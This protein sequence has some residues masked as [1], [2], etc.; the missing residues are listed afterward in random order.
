MF[1]LP[2]SK[3]AYYMSKM[4]TYKTQVNDFEISHPAQKKL[5]EL[6]QRL[7][8]LKKQSM[9]VN[10]CFILRV[11]DFRDTFQQYL[12]NHFD[13]GKRPKSNKQEK[14]R[15]VKS[16]SLVDINRINK[17]YYIHNFRNN[18]GIVL[19]MAQSAISQYHR[20]L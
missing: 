8:D 16:I 6:Q 1:P 11:N 17:Y 10:V 9:Y 7:E 14:L 20:A 3:H 19:F 18:T 4:K 12:G 5:A 13:V 2:S 15:Q